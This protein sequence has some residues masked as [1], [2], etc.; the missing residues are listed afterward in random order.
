MR[1]YWNETIGNYKTDAFRYID[2]TMVVLERLYPRR[3]SYVIVANVGHDKEVRDFSKLFYGGHI[4]LSTGD[5]ADKYLNFQKVILYP[6]EAIVVKLD[7]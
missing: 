3:H 4:V 6:G 2:K 5:Q 1:F 7:K